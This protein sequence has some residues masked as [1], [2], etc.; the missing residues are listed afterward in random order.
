MLSSYRVDQQCRPSG[1]CPETPR[2]PSTEGL[3]IFW[4]K[5]L[6]NQDKIIK[7]K[8]AKNFFLKILSGFASDFSQNIRRPPKDPPRR[9]SGQFLPG[10]N[11]WSTWYNEGEAMYFVFPVIVIVLD[12]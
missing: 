7:K 4:L 3:R 1:I 2:R 10:Q 6:A 11:Y 8:N 9:V 12:K 5:S